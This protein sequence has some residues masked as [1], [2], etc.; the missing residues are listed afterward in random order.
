MNSLAW[1]P[2]LLALPAVV[3]AAGSTM[4]REQALDAGKRF[5]DE[6]K[7]DVSGAAA[8]PEYGQVPGYRGTALPE[9]GYYDLGVGIEDAARERLP[10]NEA[11]RHVEES[12]RARPQFRIGRQDPIVRRG[13]AVGADPAAVLGTALTGEYSACE[14]TTTTAAPARYT[15]ERCTA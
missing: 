5:G 15:E 13:D 9:T 3:L 11:G 14:T 12:A 10:S 7:S 4:T 1:L 8:H 2:L 6:S